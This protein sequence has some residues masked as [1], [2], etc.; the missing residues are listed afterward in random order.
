MRI[1]L[2]VRKASREQC[3]LSARLVPRMAA[4]PYQPVEIVARRW[5][6]LE[7]WSRNRDGT[8]WNHA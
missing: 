6:S 3:S 8:M 4:I 1:D 2:L 7:K 5:I